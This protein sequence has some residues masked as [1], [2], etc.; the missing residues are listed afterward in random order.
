MASFKLDVEPKLVRL[1]VVL[2]AVKFPL[3]N[4]SQV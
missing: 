3:K 4:L 2:V 1:C